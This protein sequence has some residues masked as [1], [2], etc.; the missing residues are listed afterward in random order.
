MNSHNMKNL[1]I[2]NEEEKNRIL[3]LHETATKNHYLTEQSLDL[4]QPSQPEVGPQ[5]LHNTSG[6]I[7]K[8]GVPPDPYVYAKMGDNYYYSKDVDS[9]NPNWI[10]AKKEKS[11]NDIKSYLKDHNLIKI[12]SSAPNDVIRKLYESSMLAGEITNSNTDTLIH[13]LMKDDKEL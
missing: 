9:D 6:V 3:N 5:L 10:L 12:G 7:V 11:I 2:I 13:N 4:G 8:Q 1:F